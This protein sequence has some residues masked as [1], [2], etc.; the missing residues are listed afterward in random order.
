MQPLVLVLLA[1]T[2]ASPRQHSGLLDES[3]PAID[4]DIVARANADPKS[5]WTAAPNARFEGLTLGHVALMM[6][7]WTEDNHP[8][9]VEVPHMPVADE[10][11]TVA[12]TPSDFDPRCV[13]RARRCVSRGVPRCAAVRGHR[14]PPCARLAL[15]SRQPSPT[16]PQTHQPLSHPLTQVGLPVLPFDL[17]R[18][19]PERLWRMLGFR[20]NGGVQRPPLHRQQCD[21]HGP[22][23][24]AGHSGVLLRRRMHEQQRVRGRLAL[25]RVGV[26]CEYRHRERRRLRRR[27]PRRHL[28]SVHAFALLEQRV[29]GPPSVPVGRVHHAGLRFHLRQ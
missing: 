14:V 6:G 13:M 7:A 10:I 4:P 17:A 9:G 23:Q 20:V 25:G 16:N 8:D 28:H 5:T 26:L 2:S 21:H 24:S 27:G 19:G 12:A 29:V 22:A 18:S 11:Q 3:N 15:P 1:A